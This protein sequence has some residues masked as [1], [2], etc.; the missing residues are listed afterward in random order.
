MK[1]RRF[2]TVAVSAAALALIA[3]AS[4]WSQSSGEEHAAS[5]ETVMAEI[6]QQLDLGPN[7]RVDPAKV[8]D[9][10][11]EQLGEAVMS[12]M[13]PNERQHEF[14]DRMM[15]GEGSASL[16]AAHRWMGYRYLTGGYAAA[17]GGA[18]GGMMGS[19]M[20]GGGYAGRWGMMGD[21]EAPYG[22]IPYSSPEQIVKRRYAEDQITREQYQQMMKDLQEAPQAGG[23]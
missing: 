1:T 8:P 9:D 4:G 14:M 17:G 22:S 11:L 12:V 16:A 13:V 2:L 7:D 15:G 21:P 18:Y 3:A 10:L 5:V 6:R 23:Q 19:G 20:M